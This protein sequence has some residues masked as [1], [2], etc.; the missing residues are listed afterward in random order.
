MLQTKSHSLAARSSIL[1]T[2]N[3]GS[4][5]VHEE[6][7]TAL[8]GV[9]TMFVAELHHP[10]FAR[11]DLFSL[12]TGIMAGSPCPVNVMRRV[13]E[14]MHMSQVGSAPSSTNYLLYKTLMILNLDLL[15]ADW[16]DRPVRSRPTYMHLRARRLMIGGMGAQVSGGRD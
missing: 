2:E 5:A 15:E 6:R 3:S 4:Q 8:Y 12:R 14:D 13:R 7:C 16:P 10:D 1:L 11:F 9:P